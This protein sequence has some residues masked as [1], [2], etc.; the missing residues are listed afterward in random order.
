MILRAGGELP[1]PHAVQ[2]APER[3]PAERDTE[4]V[5]QPPQE[6]DEPP[7]HEPVELRLRPRLDRLRERDALLRR[8]QRRLARRLAIHKASR[9]RGIEARHPVADDLKT[10]A[11]DP[12]CLR[13]ARAIIDRR[14]SQKPPRLRRIP[15]V[16]R[17]KPKVVSPVIRP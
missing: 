7:A 17:Q 11:A 16:S 6:V 4:L 13:S 8:Q 12:R 3:L 10:D 5:P 14:K 9:S 2:F 1:E 15:A